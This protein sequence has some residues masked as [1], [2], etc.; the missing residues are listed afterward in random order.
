MLSQYVSLAGI[1]ITVVLAGCAWYTVLAKYKFKHDYD[2][3]LWLAV[4]LGLLP[5]SWWIAMVVWAICFQKW[6]VLGVLIGVPAFKLIQEELSKKRKSSC[7]QKEETVSYK[8]AISFSGIR[9][10]FRKRDRTQ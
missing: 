4:G 7:L 8:P 5:A 3:L 2:D 1:N 6:F 9:L 10:K